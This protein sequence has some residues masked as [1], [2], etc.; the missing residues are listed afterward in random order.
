MTEL[1][2]T[3]ARVFTPAEVRVLDTAGLLP[4]RQALAFMR[5]YDRCRRA[6]LLLDGRVSRARRHEASRPVVG[7]TPSRRERRA[8]AAWQAD[9]AALDAALACATDEAIAARDD[10]AAWVDRIDAII[11][12]NAPDGPDT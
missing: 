12:A 2:A 8:W 4:P 5:A 9:Q 1:L 6:Q 10:L 3:R 11:R 7:L